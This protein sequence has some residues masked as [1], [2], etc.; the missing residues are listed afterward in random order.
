MEIEQYQSFC[1]FVLYVIHNCSDESL[2]SGFSN[3]W[4][5]LISEA[6]FPEK[7]EFDDRNLRDAVLKIFMRCFIAVPSSRSVILN[8][9]SDYFTKHR[10]NELRYFLPLFNDLLA[11]DQDIKFAQELIKSPLMNF[12]LT[13]SKQYLEILI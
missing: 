3:Y 6:L 1:A 5:V 9:I 11:L 2:A 8:A 13:E 4:N 10:I 7:N 12:L